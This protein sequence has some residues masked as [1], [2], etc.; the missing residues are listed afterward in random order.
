MKKLV[1]III[2]IAI[3]VAGFFLIK[4]K[5]THSRAIKKETEISVV[6]IK[7]ELKE[8]AE[9]TTYSAEYEGNAT[10]ED[11]A[12]LFELKIPF[13]THK[14]EI[15]YQGVIKVSY[16]MED[17]EV[18]VDNDSKKIFITLPDDVITDNILDEGNIT[19]TDTNNIINPIG[20]QEVMDLLEEIKQ[21]ELEISTSK[22]LYDKATAHA[23]EIIV[24]LLS[25]F[26]G[27]QIVFK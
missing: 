4:D 10:I 12:V 1:G 21:Q 11:S 8:I 16:N 17:I 26:E 15:H 2:V 24:N 3:I 9:L 25:K 14:I 6:D 22:G 27:Y 18:D 7:N 23:K 20:S 19:T 13:S 5:I